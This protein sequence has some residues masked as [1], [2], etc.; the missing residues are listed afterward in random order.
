MAKLSQAFNQR[1]AQ[2]R[3]VEPPNDSAKFYLA[4]LT[5][6]EATHPSTVL[7]RQ[8]LGSR[9]L[10]EA[11]GAV[12]R[13]DYAA[14]RRWMGEARDAGVDAAGTAQIEQQIT[15]AQTNAE[16]ANE[17]ITAKAL[18]R[19]RYSTPDYPEVARS[20]G[21]QGY[22]DIIF[23]VRTD[24]SVGDVTVAGAE[25]A[26]I[27]EQAA[28]ASVRKWRYAPVIRDGRPVEQRAR[29][30]ISFAMEK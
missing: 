20:R 1:L 27:F 5:Q 9:L 10:E 14:A 26:G 15:T 16:R 6:A 19:T 11:R 17:I 4:Q 2:G 13:Q 28:M 23:T 25:P 8:A 12:T 7:A 30:R 3:L 24:G 18:T 29:V 21:A 22:V